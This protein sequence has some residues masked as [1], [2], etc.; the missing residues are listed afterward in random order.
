MTDEQLQRG[1]AMKD[2]IK[3]KQVELAHAKGKLTI[4]ARHP[5]T[6]T[7]HVLP[8]DEAAETAIQAIIVT[9]LERQLKALQAEYEA[10]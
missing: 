6:Y 7:H 1:C 3:Q 2:A 9:A 4:S 5:D 8:V 10:L